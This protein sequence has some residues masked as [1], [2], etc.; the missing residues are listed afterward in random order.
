[1]VAWQ[2]ALRATLD[3]GLINDSEEVVGYLARITGD[4]LTRDRIARDLMNALTFIDDALWCE[5]T[6]GRLGLTSLELHVPDVRQR[7]SVMLDVSG[8]ADPLADP[9]IPALLIAPRQYRSADA[10]ALFSLDYGWRLVFDVGGPA[11]YR[12]HRDAEV[13]DS[14]PISE[15]D[16]AAL[17]GGSGVLA[18]FFP[19]STR[20]A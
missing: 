18:S 4:S 11:A 8:L 7:V 20:A 10:V 17:A 2:P 13:V 3:K 12:A 14:A 1:V 5:V 15:A 16:L 19:R 9:R 6:A